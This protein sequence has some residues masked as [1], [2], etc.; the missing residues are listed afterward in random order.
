M[1]L[2]SHRLFQHYRKRLETTSCIFNPKT[3]VKQSS[4]IVTLVLI[5]HFIVFSVFY[6]IHDSFAIVWLRQLLNH[7]CSI[8]SSLT[9]FSSPSCVSSKVSSSGNHMFLQTLFISHCIQYLIVCY[10]VA[11]LYFQHLLITH[12]KIVRCLFFQARTVDFGRH[13]Q[14]YMK[15][16]L[17][18][19]SQY[20]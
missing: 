14:T 11:P 6:I 4:A 18:T 20:F 2:N 9:N 12:L 3:D 7:S 17:A 19:S 10:S 13:T 8:F 1:L 5:F 15:R 16:F